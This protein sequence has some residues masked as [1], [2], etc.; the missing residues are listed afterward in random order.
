MSEYVL[1]IQKLCMSYGSQQVLHDLSLNVEQGCIY[2]FLGRNG[3]GKSTAIRNIL[4]LLK[5]QSGIS[6]FSERIQPAAAAGCSCATSVHW[7][8]H[9]AFMTIYPV[10]TIWL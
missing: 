1:Q 6:G 5:P 7:L 2:G 8:K 10:M 9:P 3:A 4:G